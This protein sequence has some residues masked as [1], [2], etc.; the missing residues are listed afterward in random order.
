MRSAQHPTR[1]NRRLAL[2]VL[3]ALHQLINAVNMLMLPVMAEDLRLS[4]RLDA[5]ISTV[6]ALVFVSVALSTLW[7]TSFKRLPSFATT[8]RVIVLLTL[9]SLYQMTRLAV[10]AQA[11]YDRQRLPFLAILWLV[12]VAFWCVVVLGQRVRTRRLTSV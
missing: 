4:P 8:W 11:D 5:V 3:F 10:F 1:P 12:W 9:F 6:W 7:P 2:L